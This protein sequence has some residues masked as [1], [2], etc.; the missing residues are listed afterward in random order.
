[1]V[2]DTSST[3]EYRGQVKNIKTTEQQHAY[4]DIQLSFSGSAGG[5]NGSEI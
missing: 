5:C 3:I 1:M 4:F 2:E